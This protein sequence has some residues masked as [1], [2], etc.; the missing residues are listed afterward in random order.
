VLPT[1]GGTF[2]NA[3]SVD[4]GLPFFYGRNVYEVFEGHSTAAGTGPYVAF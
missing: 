4:L 2:P 3:T 1:L